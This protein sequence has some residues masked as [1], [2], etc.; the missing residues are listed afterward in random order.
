SEAQ[1]WQLKAGIR[2]ALDDIRKNH[3]NDLASLNHWSSHDAYNTPRVV[4]GRSFDKMTNCL[5]YPYSLVNNLSTVSSERRPYATATISSSNPCGLDELDYQAD[6]PNADGGTNPTMGLMVAYNQFNWTGGY[7]GRKGAAKIV[8]LETDG[9]ANQKCNGTLTPISGGGGSLQW[10]TISNG[11]SAPN[12]MNGHPQALEPAISLGW[13]ISQ[14]ATGSKN[15]PTFPGHTNGNGLATQGP[16][17]KWAGL[18]AN[19]PGYASARLP[20]QIHTIAFG[21]LFEDS[22]SSILKRRALEF[23]RDVQ[24]TSGLQPDPTTGTIEDYKR[25]VGTY[26]QRIDKLRQALERIMQSGIQVAL[27]E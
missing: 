17:A 1:C 10:T 9:V 13:L 11:G 27:I 20:A 19:G 3:P 5:Y 22:T 26:D 14:D 25:I 12:P 15:W 18:T 6:I 23:L 21:Y 8:I 4:M 24:L 7:T 16:P 2:S